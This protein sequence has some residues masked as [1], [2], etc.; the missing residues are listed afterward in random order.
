MGRRVGILIFC[1]LVMVLASRE[2]MANNFLTHEEQIWL[3]EH[4]SDLAVL[5]GYEAPPN[6]FHDDQGKYV[7]LLVD[8]YREIEKIL[9]I[10]IPMRKFS[11][12]DELMDYS[13]RGNNFIVVGIAETFNRS[14]YLSFTSPFI[15][16]PYVIVTRDSSDIQSMG[17][18]PG[19]KLCTVTG[20]AVNDYLEYN[21][22]ELVPYGV[23]DNLAGL[24]AVSTGRF[25]AM[26]LN[27][28]YASNIIQRE[29][30]SN[31][32]IAGESGYLN[33]LSAAASREDNILFSILDKAVDQI[34][35]A[36]RQA[37]Y[38]GWVSGYKQ[39]FP[40]SYLVWSI[41]GAVLAVVLIFVSWGA[42]WFLRRG[43]E[44]KKRELQEREQ[45]YY[46][47]FDNANDAIFVR[48]FTPD[49]T[50]TFTDVNAVACSR[51]EYTRDEFLTL[52]TWDIDKR[53]EGEVVKPPPDLVYD[54]FSVFERVHV[55][56]SGKEIPVEISSR[57][58]DFRGTTYVLS[59]ARDISGRKRAE[60]ELLKSEARL[61]AMIDTVPAMMFAKNMDGRFLVANR[62]L[63]ENLGVTVDELIGRLYEEVQSGSDDLQQMMKDERQAF[64]ADE[65][66]RVRKKMFSSG[67]ETPR[68]LQVT[69]VACPEEYFGE[70]AIVGT[71][72]DVTELKRKESELRKLRGYLANIINSMPSVVIGVDADGMITQWNLEAERSLGV[73]ASEAKG[74]QLGDVVERLAPE[75]DRVKKAIATGQQQSDLRRHFFLDEAIYYEDLTVYPLVADG[76]EGA[77]IRIDDVTEQVHLEQA[78]VQSEKMSS[79]GGLAAGM[80][81]EIN[82][83][84]AA[85]IAAAQN[86][87]KRVSDSLPKNKEIA[88]EVGLTLEVLDGY[89]EKRNVHKLLDGIYDSGCNAAKIV[90]NMLRFSRRN[91]GSFEYV[92]L[93]KLFDETLELA[94]GDYEL[95]R[96]YNFLGISVVRDYAENVPD[97]FCEINEI[98]Q[99]LLNLVKNA[100]QAMMDKKY[101][102]EKPTLTCKVWH[103]GA[104]VV[105]EVEDNG[106][107]MDVAI[108][109]QVFDPFFTTRLVGEGSGLG[110]SVSYFIVVDNHSGSM[111]VFSSPGLWTRFVVRLPLSGGR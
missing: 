46:L 87:K 92:N 39:A 23:V 54:G 32:R 17:D 70:P 11:T 83:P 51:L 33:R 1:V 42:V 7:G 64:D 43:L 14:Q 50:A 53:A 34:T 52:T 22:P 103:D 26:I 74:R 69:K 59:M 76:A 19:K 38:G 24:R 44:E 101:G 102:D 78:L 110:L 75:M 35:P 86:I 2:L 36:T 4:E 62:A 21:Y 107:G 28:M 12:W 3:D 106:P 45:E 105:L 27:Q 65:M 104:D 72:I 97:V 37:L 6:A 68:W 8:F 15:K 67:S 100:A 5:F 10:S 60:A 79:L 89:L 57:L 77:V 99:V 48:P 108:R 56:K 49:N 111:E 90:N 96:S 18:L 85:I 13:K 63:A 98:Q 47:I 58:F 66:F 71:A 93:A 82:N 95:K 16:I 31:L 55:S 20:Y 88:D 29:G 94:S 109:K 25:D 84:L 40:K 30:L 81:H 41:V 91:A 9:G 73:L 61:R 80:A